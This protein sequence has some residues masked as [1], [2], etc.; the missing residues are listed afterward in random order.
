MKCEAARRF[1]ANFEVR[2]A[3]DALD[4]KSG[5]DRKLLTRSLINWYR[6]T[7]KR[8]PPQGG[9]AMSEIAVQK[10]NGREAQVTPARQEFEPFRLMREML[11]WDPFQEMRPLWGGE[12]TSFLPAFEV[13]ENKDSFVFKADVP[14]VKEQDI[15]VTNTGSRLTV[16]GKR[17]SEKEEKDDTYYAC[18]RTYGSFSRSFTLPEQ[19]DASHIKAEMKNGELT[20]VVP[21]TSAAVAKKVPISLGDKPKG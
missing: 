3:I 19:A 11:R 13:K 6:A 8:A 16:S 2:A 1:D 18:E 7:R 9:D 14:G 12:V 20:I 4:R 21:K 10:R 17:E 15:E 5:L